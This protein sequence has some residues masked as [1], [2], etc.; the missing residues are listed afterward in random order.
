MLHL[1]KILNTDEGIVLIVRDAIGLIIVVVGRD[2]VPQ[3]VPASLAV[4]VSMSEDHVDEI[5]LLT[6]IVLVRDVSAARQLVTRQ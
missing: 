3:S 5:L 6:T 1:L 2:V 4:V